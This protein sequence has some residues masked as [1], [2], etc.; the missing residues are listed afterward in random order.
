MSSRYGVS[1]CVDN[2]LLK[3]MAGDCEGAAEVVVE[4]EEGRVE[5]LVVVS[6]V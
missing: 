2:W 4:E 6:V 1:C 5:V 3:K